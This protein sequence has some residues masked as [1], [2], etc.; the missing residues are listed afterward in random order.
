LGFTAVHYAVHANAAEALAVLI[1]SG[2]NI[3]LSSLFD[4]L[5]SLCCARGSTPLHISA[6]NGN[7]A[8]AKQ[9]LRA[10]VSQLCLDKAFCDV[11]CFKT[12]G[13]SATAVLFISA[14]PP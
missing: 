3:L 14:S 11:N 13:Q 2:A 5:D 6:R 10:W 4:C 12:L 1:N 7:T 8:I 9:L